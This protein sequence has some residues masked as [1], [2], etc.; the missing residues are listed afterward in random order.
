VVIR[1]ISDS[2]NVV[3][4]VEQFNN[5]T[6]NPNS[7]D[8]VA[9]KIGDYRE[10][11]SESE[12]RYIQEGNYQNN[13]QYVYISMNTD[14]DAGVT[15]AALLPFGFQGIV[16][17]EDEENLSGSV[18]GNWVS[19][20]LTVPSGYTSNAFVISGSSVTAS[21]AYPRPTLRLSASDGNLSNPTDAYFGLQTTPSAA[22]TRYE[23]STIDL[24][25]PRGG[26]V[27]VESALT[28]AATV[29]SPTFTLDDIA[30]GSLAE[31]VYVTGSHA[32][33]VSGAPSG[34]YTFASGAIAGV[35]GAGYDRFTVPLFGGFDG[36]DILEMDPFANRTMSATGSDTNSYEF[37][38]IRRA[39]DSVADPEVVEMHRM[40]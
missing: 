36:T 40:V 13:S 1:H 2:D 12:R 30:S 29:L 10:V 35:L 11:W 6:L 34:S 5:C 31:G 20:S 37:F 39:I 9:R 7:L 32:G 17:Y 24:L 27:D 3:R 19:G 14:V 15:D 18:T 21:V 22:S 4:V 16:K 26:I 25:R 28:S 38:S 8:Y 23:K 33:V